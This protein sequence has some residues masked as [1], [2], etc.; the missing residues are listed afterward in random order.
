MHG[1]D[2]DVVRNNIMQEYLPNEKQY[3]KGTKPQKE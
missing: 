2:W 3:K 1:S